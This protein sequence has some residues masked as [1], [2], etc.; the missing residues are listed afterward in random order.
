MEKLL[1]HVARAVGFRNELLN[2][3]TSGDRVDMEEPVVS[4]EFAIYGLEVR[5][6][7]CV[8]VCGC[9]CVGVC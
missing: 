8:C 4:L 5:V 7:V 1:S 9:V 6:G 3:L 2:R